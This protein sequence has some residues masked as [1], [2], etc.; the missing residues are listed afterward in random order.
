MLAS[1]ITHVEIEIIEIIVSCEGCWFISI[2]F[3]NYH[4]INQIK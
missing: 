2:D 3:D 1:E 4:Q